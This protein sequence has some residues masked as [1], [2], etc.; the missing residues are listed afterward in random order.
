M[1]HEV[2]ATPTDG[3]GRRVT[4]TCGDAITLEWYFTAVSTYW[5]TREHQAGRS[6]LA[7]IRSTA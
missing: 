2:A 6:F 3:G 5:L 1:T 7:I 4:C